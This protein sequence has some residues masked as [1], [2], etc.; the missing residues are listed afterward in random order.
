MKKTIGYFGLLLALMISITGCRGSGESSE[1][2]GGTP[3]D[4]A[5]TTAAATETTAGSETDPAT[6]T[7]APADTDP[8]TE[9]VTAEDTAATE[10]AALPAEYAVGTINA[11]DGATNTSNKTRLHNPAYVP[12]AG[13]AGVTVNKGYQLTWLAYGE[14]RNYLGNGNNYSG[15][16]QES[17]APIRT[18]DILQVYPE[19]IYFRYAVKN[20]SGTQLSLSDVERSGVTLL[21]AGAEIPSANGEEKTFSYSGTGFSTE[22]TVTVTL[23]RTLS[24]GQDGAVWGDLVFRFGN[25]GT[26]TV[27]SL[28]ECRVVG[29]VTMDRTDLICPHSNSASFGTKYYADGDEFPLLYSN[30]YNNYASEA[31]RRIGYCCV[32]R[33]TRSGND[34]RAALVQ[35]IRIGFAD[36]PGLWTSKSGNGDVRP[37]GN[38][39]V[40]DKNDLLWAFVMRD[41]DSCTRIFS[42]DLPDPSAGQSDPAY[43]GVPVVT[44]KEEDIRDRFDGGYSHYLQGA[45]VAD[46]LIYSLEGFTDSAS[47]P[48]AIRIFDT[49]SKTEVGLVDLRGNGYGTE[50]EFISVYVD[51]LLYSDSVGRL[52]SLK[53]N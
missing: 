41:A 46:G 43:P 35:I 45:T 22:K 18:S 4:T 38:F 2:A 10:P 15:L 44:L 12:I 6:A 29:S 5:G 37:Y 14:N 21:P 47:S 11:K 9:P 52:Y 17:G 13:S 16:W 53:F 40:D 30:V 23:L 8:V 28:P 36:G 34:F 51:T 24:G 48:A 19:A 33:L 7:E 3:P 27:V 31:D 25:K 39:V 20:V 1:T 32:Y 26:G 50:P 49:R 42:F